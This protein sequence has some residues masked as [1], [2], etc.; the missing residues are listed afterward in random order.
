MPLNICTSA[1]VY[2]SESVSIKFEVCQHFS[3]LS[4]H[5]GSQFLATTIKR[6]FLRFI[7]NNSKNNNNNN[8]HHHV[9]NFFRQAFSE[10]TKVI[11]TSLIPLVTILPEECAFIIGFSSSLWTKMRSL[12]DSL[13]DGVLAYTNLIPSRPLIP[14]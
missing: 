4:F 1:S 7:H 11:T 3:G 10:Y 14:L 2:E 8:F 9:M 13:A 12:D 5:S 6:C